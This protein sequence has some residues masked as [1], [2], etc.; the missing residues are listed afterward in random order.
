MVTGSS[1][2]LIEEVIRETWLGGGEVEEG[3]DRIQATGRA[4]LQ[5]LEYYF[6]GLLRGSE[7]VEELKCLSNQSHRREAKGQVMIIIL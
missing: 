1:C 5:R 2:V 3:G 4:S 7:T 6:K